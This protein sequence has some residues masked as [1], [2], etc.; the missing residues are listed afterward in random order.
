[1]HS[2]NS[3]FSARRSL[4]A[5]TL[6]EEQQLDFKSDPWE[7][8]SDRV[9]VRLRSRHQLSQASLEELARQGLQLPFEFTIGRRLDPNLGYHI[10]GAFRGSEVVRVRLLPVAR[11]N[12][13]RMIPPWPVFKARLEAA[14]GGTLVYA[15]D[16]TQKVLVLWRGPGWL[17]PPEVSRT[18]RG[19]RLDTTPLLRGA[20]QELSEERW[21]RMCWDASR[22]RD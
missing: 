4:I 1:M 9:V 19:G 6:P 18:R 15:D 7:D 11:R 5:H 20:Q 22:L 3:S 21:Q 2:G 10:K 14:T 8:T 16:M 17:P 13:G 12:L